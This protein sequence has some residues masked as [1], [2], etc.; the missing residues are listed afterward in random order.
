[1]Q[2]N[3]RKAWSVSSKLSIIGRVRSGAETPAKI[4]QELHIPESTLRSWLKDEDKI[5]QFADIVRFSGLVPR[6]RARLANDHKLDTLMYRWYV[7]QQRTSGVAPT[8]SALVSEAERRD[9]RLNGEASTFRASSGWVFRFFRRHGIGKKNSVAR[10]CSRDDVV[11][12][13]DDH[14][15]AMLKTLMHEEGYMPEQIYNGSVTIVDYKTMPGGDEMLPSCLRGKGSRCTLLLCTN[16][17]GSHKLKPLCIGNLRTPPSL[18]CTDWKTMPA[19]YADSADAHMTP[20][21][22]ASWFRD[23]FVPSVRQY[24]RSNNV[25]ERALLLLR[26]SPTSLDTETLSSPDGLIKASFLP[27]HL[28]QPLDRGIVA[29]FRKIFRQNLL[30]DIIASKRPVMDFLKEISI[31][32]FLCSAALA[33]DR[34]GASTIDGCWMRALGDAFVVDSGSLSSDNDGNHDNDVGAKC[35]VFDGFTSCRRSRL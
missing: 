26:R 25:P 7:R 15:P 23:Q 8:A 19:A 29:Y 18:R 30:A 13:A 31:N 32:D 35:D 9:R 17:T 16:K 24:L 1:M 28:T 27:D 34:V 6:K 20:G 10:L 4:C 3:K 12:A 14:Y 11:E 5:R 21:I 33:W 22:F 2:K